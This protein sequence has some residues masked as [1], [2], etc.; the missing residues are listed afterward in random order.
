MPISSKVCDT[1]ILKLKH[2]VHI[3]QSSGPVRER[4][5]QVLGAWEFAWQE[6]R[7]GERRVWVEGLWCRV[8]DMENMFRA[9]WR[10][11]TT[12]LYV[13]LVI[14]CFEVLAEC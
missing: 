9:A 13:L 11:G 6:R 8:S 10:L 5:E 2:L 7:D 1:H 3:K 14:H 4:R 12:T